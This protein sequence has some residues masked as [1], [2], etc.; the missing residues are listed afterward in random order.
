MNVLLT[1]GTGF[2]GP[3]VARALVRAGHEVRCLVRRSSDLRALQESGVALGFANGDVCERGSLDAALTGMQAVV[4][5]A[6]LTKCIRSDELYRVNAGGTRNLAE[7]AVAAGVKR[8][9]HCS[10][11]SVAGPI[12]A[13][14]PSRE[15]DVPAPVSHYGRSKLAAEEALRHHAGRLSLTIVRPP[16]VYGPRDRD[17]LEVFRMAA[18]RVAVKPGLFREKRYSMIYVEDLGLAL[19]SALDRGQAVVPGERGGGGVYYVSD[20]GVYGWEELLR[21]VGRAVGRSNTFVLPIP[22]ALSWPVGLWGELAARLSGKSQIM[23]IDKVR[24]LGGDGWACEVGRAHRELS[25]SAQYPLS[26]GLS[27]A[28]SWYREHRWI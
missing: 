1:G 18:R 12:A 20:G 15:E 28:A 13:G 16:I 17:F 27:E 19:A 24:E 14:R 21:H 3:A 9:V 8:F 10:S 26:R 4:H 22:E 23:S 6:G 25:W 5:V 7:A 2:V 11:L